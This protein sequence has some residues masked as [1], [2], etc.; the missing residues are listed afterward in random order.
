MGIQSLGSNQPGRTLSEART[1]AARAMAERDC[2]SIRKAFGHYSKTH[3]KSF[4]SL[5]PSAYFGAASG[6]RCADSAD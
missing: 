4:V 5:V 3:T 1:L 2:G 6:D